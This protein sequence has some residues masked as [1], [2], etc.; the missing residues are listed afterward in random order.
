[1]TKEQLIA[2][3]TAHYDE[4]NALNKVDNFFD[5]ESDLYKALGKDGQRGFRKEYQHTSW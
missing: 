1:M 5:Y 2:S 4:P 3:V